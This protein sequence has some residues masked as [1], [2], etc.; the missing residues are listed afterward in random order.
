MTA[1]KV[2]SAANAIQHGGSHYK[3]L[4]IQPWDYIT[5]NDIG[6]LEGNAIKYLTRW[7]EKGGIEDI[8]KAGHYVQK[9]LEVETAK[10][11]T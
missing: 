3:Q 7:R 8:R 9:L 1:K 2:A 5:S 11:A 10:A 4:P 6:F